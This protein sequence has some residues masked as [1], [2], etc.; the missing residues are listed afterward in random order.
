MQRCHHLS[1]KL[2]VLHFRRQSFLKHNSYS[3]SLPPQAPATSHCQTEPLLCL[4]TD[5]RIVYTLKKNVIKPVVSADALWSTYKTDSFWVL[6]CF[7]F[8][9]KLGLA[10]FYSH[11]TKIS[12]ILNALR[13][14]TDFHLQQSSL[15]HTPRCEEQG[16]S[17]PRKSEKRVGW[18]LSHTTLSQ[19]GKHNHTTNSFQSL[20]QFH[21]T[22]ARKVQLPG[23]AQRQDKESNSYPA[24]GQHYSSAAVTAK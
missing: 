24:W 16:M 18:Q 4:G 12:F 1:L 14:R 8:M 17:L 15:C 23:L 7:L 5:V 9:K 21:S 19:Q 10:F 3:F 6:G 22:D 11:S 20:S 13:Y 2:S